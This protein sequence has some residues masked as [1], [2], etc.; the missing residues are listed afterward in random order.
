[1]GLPDILKVHDI[2]VQMMYV[3]CLV[4]FSPGVLEFCCKIPVSMKSI[5]MFEWQTT[6]GRRLDD[7]FQTFDQHCFVCVTDVEMPQS[8]FY[9]LL[10][11]CG[12]KCG[13]GIKF[14]FGEARN[15]VIHIS[16]Q[17]SITWNNPSWCKNAE[18]SQFNTKHILILLIIKWDWQ[19]VAYTPDVV[20]HMLCTF[21]VG[22]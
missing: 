15:T 20:L 22:S 4:G 10:A 7:I 3:V 11:K 18:F 6:F 19:S 12:M 9:K 14:I 2:T 13:K 21:F 16:V 8:S 17:K 1:M 5:W